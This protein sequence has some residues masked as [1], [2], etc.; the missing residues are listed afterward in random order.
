MRRPLAVVAGAIVSLAPFARR[1]CT[2][3]GADRTD[4]FGRR[5]GDGAC[6]SAPPGPARPSTVTVVS[7]ADGRFKCAPDVYETREPPR[8]DPANAQRSQASRASH[9][10]WK[11]EDPRAVSSLFVG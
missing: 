8:V 6:G 10:A 9:D 11:R 7:G 4:Q 1:L 5:G 2:N 3:A